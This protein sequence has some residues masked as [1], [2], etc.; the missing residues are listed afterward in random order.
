[1]EKKLSILLVILGV[2]FVAYEGLRFH[3]IR[4]YNLQCRNEEYLSLLSDDT[5]TDFILLDT[6]F[7]LPCPL[8]EFEENG[9]KIEASQDK[10]QAHSTMSVKVIK[11]NR[12]DN[13]VLANLSD[14]DICIS[15]ATVVRMY[16][17]DYKRYDSSYGLLGIGGNQV[18]IKRGINLY[19]S[20]LKMRKLLND[21]EGF[22]GEVYS[23]AD[24]YSQIK[25][26]DGDI[27][28][29]EIGPHQNNASRN[30][31]VLSVISDKDYKKLIRIR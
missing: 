18:V 21:M 7:C 13:C 23:L 29:I 2:L 20:D 1:M 30:R 31:I 9:W 24:L 5:K 27:C 28:R 3:N 10:M 16:F 15:E 11:G 6:Y 22:D 4:Y 14:G 25:V 17:D 12:K 26:W 8:S 19:T